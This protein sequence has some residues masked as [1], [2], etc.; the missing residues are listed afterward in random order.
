MQSGGVLVQ[1]DVIWIA[2]SM[3]LMST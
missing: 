1:I 3:I 2:N